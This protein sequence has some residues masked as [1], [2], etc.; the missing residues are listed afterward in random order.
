ML[1]LF[2]CCTHKKAISFSLLCGGGGGVDAEE[3][4]AVEGVVEKVRE[5]K[6]EQKKQAENWKK[7]KENAVERQNEFNWKFAL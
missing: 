3:E 7:I 4:A 6:K 1:I 5:W 2:L